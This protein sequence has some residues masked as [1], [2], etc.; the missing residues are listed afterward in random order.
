[1]FGT[2]SE[3]HHLLYEG[4]VRSLVDTFI[5]GA[6]DVTIKTH[7]IDKRSR[8]QDGLGFVRFPLTPSGIYAAYSAVN[9]MGSITLDGNL[10]HIEFQIS[11]NLKANT[12]PVPCKQRPT[13]DLSVVSHIE[14]PFVEI[15]NGQPVE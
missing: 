10:F 15:R 12:M 3:I 11:D 14:L 9:L 1:M 4:T 6:I 5:V 7:H 8:K 13:T 2:Q